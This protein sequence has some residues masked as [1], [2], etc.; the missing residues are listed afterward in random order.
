MKTYRNKF[1]YNNASVFLYHN[2]QFCYRI[3][4]TYVTYTVQYSTVVYEVKNKQT[5]SNVDKDFGPPL[6]IVC[7]FLSSVF[8]LLD[9]AP[10]LSL[11]LVRGTTY[12]LMLPPHRHCFHLSSDLKCTYFVCHIS[13]LPFNYLTVSPLPLFCGHCSR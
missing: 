4:L 6:P 3:Y 9:V 13:V 12:L 11:V 10:F 5:L 7:L 8:L 1:C 2:V